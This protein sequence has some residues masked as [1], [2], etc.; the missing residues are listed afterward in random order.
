MPI[1]LFKC[2]QCCQEFEEI[3]SS[4]TKAEETLS[5]VCPSCGDVAWKIKAPQ[6]T[7]FLGKKGKGN[8]VN[9]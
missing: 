9:V 4:I 8:W 3:F 5:M 2:I 1:K 7:N 6:P